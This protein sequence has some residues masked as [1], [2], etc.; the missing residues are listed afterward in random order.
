[1]IIILHQQITASVFYTADSVFLT[2]LCKLANDQLDTFLQNY[3]LLVNPSAKTIN[4]FLVVFLPSAWTNRA[5]VIQDKNT[6]DFE[7]KSSII[8]LI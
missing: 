7:F 6:L 2:P 8:L 3:L 4:T 5:T 1:M